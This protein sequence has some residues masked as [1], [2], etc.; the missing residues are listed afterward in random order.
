MFVRRTHLNA[1][2]KWPLL[3]TGLARSR[4]IVRLSS[5]HSTSGA[6]EPGG[7]EGE[8]GVWAGVWIAEATIPHNGQPGF[9]AKDMAG[10]SSPGECGVGGS[11]QG[12]QTNAGDGGRQCHGAQCWRLMSISRCLYADAAACKRADLPSKNLLIPFVTDLG[13]LLSLGAGVHKR[14]HLPPPLR[15]RLNKFVPSAPKWP[16]TARHPPGRRSS[17]PSSLSG[18]SLTTTTT[19]GSASSRFRLPLLC[20][21]NH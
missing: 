19:E 20:D 9:G 18:T 6:L 1:T 16:S 5:R 10:C 7:N 3:E 14:S 13:V 2:I 21:R 8:R 17:P 11:G 4:Y 15:R 12:G